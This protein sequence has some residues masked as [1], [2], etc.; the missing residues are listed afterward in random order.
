MKKR[1]VGLAGLF[2]VVGFIAGCGEKGVS[3][4]KEVSVKKEDVGKPVKPSAKM[5]DDIYVEFIAQNAYLMGKYGQ[6]I[7][8]KGTAAGIKAGAEL[9]AEWEKLYKKLGVSEKS[10]NEY[11]EKITE[12]PTRYME[13]MQKVAERVEELQK[14]GK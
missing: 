4:E 8:G 10:L 14:T 11:G 5:T 7:E 3:E 2:L 6:K 9:A 1:I 12:D 13:L